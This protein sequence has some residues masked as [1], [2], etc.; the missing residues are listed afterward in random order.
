M[1]LQHA[2]ILVVEC[3]SLALAALPNAVDLKFLQLSR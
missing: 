1:S 2:G 3:D